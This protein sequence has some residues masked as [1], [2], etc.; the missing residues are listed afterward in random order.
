MTISPLPPH[1]SHAP[2]VPSHAFASTAKIGNSSTQRRPN[3]VFVGD[4]SYF[5][6][7]KDL[8]ELFTQYGQVISCHIVYNDQRT[9]SLMYGFVTMSTEAEARSVSATLNNQVFMGRCI[10]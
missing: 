8:L 7:E 4:L 1:S 5:C 6:R 3:D 10:K 2:H 9:R